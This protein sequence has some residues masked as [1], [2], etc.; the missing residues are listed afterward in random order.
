MDVYYNKKENSDNDQTKILFRHYDLV[1]LHYPINGVIRQYG[2]DLINKGYW[3]KNASFIGRCNKS[4]RALTRE[5]F[6]FVRVH[7]GEKQM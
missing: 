7:I 6:H 4:Y 3:C 1:L 2:A 5:A